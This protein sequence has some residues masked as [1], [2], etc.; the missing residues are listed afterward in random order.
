MTD[1]GA[2]PFGR[3]VLIACLVMVLAV[4][5]VAAQDLADPTAAQVGLFD[6]RGIPVDVTAQTAAA[7]REQAMSKGARDAFWQ[8]IDRMTLSSDRAKVG[9]VSDAQIETMIRD[10]SVAD[11]KYSSVRYIATLNYTFKEDEV[12]LLLAQRGVPYALTRAKTLVVLPVLRSEGSLVLWDEPN[13]WLA[14]WRALPGGQ[15]VP[16]MI[17]MGDAADMAAID[18]EQAAVGD[19]D[20]MREIALHYGA[21]DALVPFAV[22]APDTGSGAAELTVA[23]TLYGAD[24]ARKGP[25]RRYTATNGESAD[26][27]L[28][29][30]AEA[31]MTEVQ[32]QWKREN[33][34]VASQAA[35]ESV[36]VPISS[37]EDW[38]TVRRR[39]DGVETIEKTDVVLLT[40][41]HALINIHHY[42]TAEQL[43]LALE[44]ADLILRQG[45]EG[46]VLTA[47]PRS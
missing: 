6:V 42:G 24:G 29:R 21:V 2:S 39:L 10:F 5:R 13:P 17:P 16:V 4:A 31:T 47:R 30:A 1:R 23:L 9:K 18:A 45:A 15:L 25:T 35:V 7:A 8:L 11:E 43:G 38:L 14:A 32:N 37:L 33:L 26:D 36:A 34:V 12:R 28:A 27:L 20:R 22:L 46:L 44:Q 41:S 40:R 19:A 3:P